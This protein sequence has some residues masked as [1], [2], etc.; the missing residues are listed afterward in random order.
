MGTI[1]ISVIVAIVITLLIAVPITCKVAVSNKVKQDAEKVGTAEEKARSIIDEALKTAETKN[2]KPFW[3][4]RKNLSERKTNWR[5]KP[6]NEEPNCKSMKSASCQRESVDRKS[7][8]L[9][10]REAEY[11]NKEE[12]LRKKRK[13]SRRITCTGSTG[14]GTNFRSDLR[15]GKRLSFKSC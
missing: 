11:A 5:K 10:R 8:A 2:A 1:I 9:E 12:Q 14:T 3:K 4:R 15:T 6:K 7:D 13:E